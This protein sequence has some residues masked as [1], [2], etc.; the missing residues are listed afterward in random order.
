MQ[1]YLE[2]NVGIENLKDPVL[3]VIQFEKYRSDTSIEDHSNSL[4]ASHDDPC[5]ELLN[6]LLPLDSAL[7][8]YSL[9]PPSS[10]SISKKPANPATGSQIFSLGHFRSYS[11]PSLPQVSGSPSS[12]GSLSNPNPSIDLEDFSHIST[13]KLIK[14]Q[15]SGNVGLLSFRGVPLEPERFS[16]HCGLEGIYLPGRRWRRKLE[17]IQPVEIQS[18]AA[19]C[20]TEDLLCVQIKVL[21]SFSIY[22]FFCPFFN[23]H[24]IFISWY[25][26]HSVLMVMFPFAECFSNSYTRFNYLPGCNKHCL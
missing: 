26:I 5:R 6:W 23:L 4:V 10:S 17:I 19:D 20:N 9:S 8:P 14:S 12:V 18:F 16:A 3:E 1:V 22:S 11:L 13:E 2:V 7:P 21:V 15:D 24:I 25:F